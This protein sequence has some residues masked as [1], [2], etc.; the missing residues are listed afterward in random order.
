MQEHQGQL[1]CLAIPI[2]IATTTCRIDFDRTTVVIHLPDG[3]RTLLRDGEIG[4]CCAACW[5]AIQGGKDGDQGWLES[6][7]YRA[8]WN[9]SGTWSLYARQGDAFVYIAKVSGDRAST[10]DSLVVQLIKEEP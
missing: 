8:E 3:W 4:F 2:C 1:K 10:L 9:G 7:N 6:R 5:R